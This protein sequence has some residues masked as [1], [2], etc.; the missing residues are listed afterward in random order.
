VRH[1]VELHGGSVWADSAG[2]NQ[3]CAFTVHLPLALVANAP[4]GRPPSQ[5][6]SSNGDE[7]LAGVKILLVEDDDDSRELMA[8]MLRQRGAEVTVAASA[9]DAFA[10][11]QVDHP[12]VLVSDIGM[13]EEDGYTLLARI[14]ALPAE[15]GGR[16]PAVALT[17]LARPEDRRRALHAGYEVHVPKP[18]D[19]AELVAVIANLATPSSSR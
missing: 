4:A 11:F 1:L 8:R 10:I 16:V 14:R 3:G 15:K 13:P 6:A 19:A 2:E 9:A 12:D 7:Q 18:A 17:A 5:A